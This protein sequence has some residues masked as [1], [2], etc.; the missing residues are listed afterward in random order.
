MSFYFEDDTDGFDGVNYDP[1]SPGGAPEWVLRQDPAN[2]MDC[3]CYE[4]GRCPHRE[5]ADEYLARTWSEQGIR[6]SQIS[7]SD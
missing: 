5:S 7:Q 3:G 4:G 1:E 2:Y 6:T